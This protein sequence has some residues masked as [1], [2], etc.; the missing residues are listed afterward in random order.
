[1][2][3]TAFPGARTGVRPRKG[4]EG[5]AVILVIALL[6]VLLIYITAGVRTL[7]NL[8]RDVRLIEKQQVQRLQQATGTTNQ[9]STTN[10]PAAS[11]QP[12]KQQE[13]GLSG[14]N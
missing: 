9:L 4:E 2:K 11:A 3:T 13:S 6:V 12:P 5:M 1:M 8:G 7:N 10:R 14:G